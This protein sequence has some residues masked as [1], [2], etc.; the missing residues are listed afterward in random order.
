MNLIGWLAVWLFS[1]TALCA[2][3]N[4]MRMREKLEA[5]ELKYQLEQKKRAEAEDQLTKTELRVS[6]FV[7]KVSPLIAKTD[8]MTGR[9]KGQFQTLVDL[10]NQRNRDVDTARKAIWEIPLLKR[11]PIKPTVYTTKDSYQ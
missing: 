3:Y 11:N 10:E 9:W 1:G 2:G 7:V 6:E 5:A 8:W 4:T